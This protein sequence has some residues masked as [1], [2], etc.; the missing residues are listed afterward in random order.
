LVI[1]I[2]QGDQNFR[3]LCN[4]LLWVFFKKNLS[5][6]KFC[7]TFSEELTDINFEKGW[8]GFTLGNF[9]TKSSGQPSTASETDDPE[10]IS[11]NNM[12]NTRLFADV[13]SA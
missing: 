5:D 13:H 2:A 3:P 12:I 10:F 8:L 7:A 11:R 6:Q 1:A 4:C 9:S